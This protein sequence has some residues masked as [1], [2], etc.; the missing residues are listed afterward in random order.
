[1]QSH[2][3]SNGVSENRG[4]PA[5]ASVLALIASAGIAILFTLT[6]ARQASDSKFPSIQDVAAE[7]GT[8]R[9]QIYYSGTEIS[10]LPALVKKGAVDVKDAHIAAT[11]D[12]PNERLLID[13]ESR[14]VA[15]VF[16]YLTKSPENPRGEAWPVPADELTVRYDGCRLFP[17]ALFATTRQTIR[18]VDEDPLPNYMHVQAIINEVHVSLLLDMAPIQ[19]R[20]SEKTPIEVFCDFHSWESGYWLI[21]DHPFAASSNRRGE[22][23]ITGLP[24]GKHTLKIWHE[25][26]GYVQRG[27]DV[28][29]V[30]GETLDLGRIEFSQ[31]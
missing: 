11:Q 18:V 26:V 8:I 22:F 5:A 2:L 21:L 6:P 27:L 20:R 25:H 23:A 15:N 30:A 19:F 10:D 16:V 28:E 1:M 3:S 7:S 12:I 29:V 24:P 13:P 9:G 17:H 14:G 4:Q 31:P